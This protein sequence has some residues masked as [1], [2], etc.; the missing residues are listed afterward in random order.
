MTTN[1]FFYKYQDSSIID[2]L[3][4]Y[5]NLSVMWE[6]TVSKYSAAP[7]VEYLG[8]S[9]SYSELDEDV[10]H[11][12]KHLL[13]KGLKS[14]DTVC[15]LSDRSYDFIKAFLAA[16]T[17]GITVA[18]LPLHLNP[19]QIAHFF[20]EF[21]AAALLYSPDFREV[22][23]EDH[24]VSLNKINIS[25][26]AESSAPAFCDYPRETPC[27]IMFT[28]GTLGRSKGAVLSHEA[29]MQGII[30]GCYGYNAV[31][32]QKYLLVL[33]LFHVFGLIRS[34]LTPLYTGSLIFINTN[35]R[36]L[37]DDLAAFNP[38]VTV[39]VP[40]LVERGIA[41]SQKFG[42][43][44][45]GN[46]MKYIITGAAP[47]APY[48]AEDCAKYGITLCMGYGLTETACLVSG[49]PDMLGKPGSVGLL[50][51]NQEYRLVNDELW[52]KGRNLLTRYRDEEENQN[53]FEDGWFKTGD[54]VRIDDDG[55]MY[56]I[57]R[58]KEMLLRSNGENVYPSVVE[59]KFNALR[60]VNAS[61][62]YISQDEDGHDILAL[63]VL[64]RDTQPVIDN[65]T[66]KVASMMSDL[67][68][69]NDS[70]PSF[71]RAKKII[72]RR[73]DFKRTASMKI[74]RY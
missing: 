41:L 62:L 58:K 23:K 33:P 47:I 22:I 1:N 43:S 17:L 15:L 20:N 50:Y 70:L 56:V 28:G 67:N 27:I 12:R 51:P 69:I 30:N 29:V 2:S 73:E 36:M 44:M 25:E 39:L 57:G 49:N 35:P 45:F 46:S 9:Y 31:F 7:A 71:Q 21:G 54:A 32:G 14:T 8:K 16:E 61:Q 63:E 10:S 34:V 19:A 42:R 53:S 60:W 24:P 65:I 4:E 18:V 26:S 55:F 66:D 68:R 40:L 13:D 5:E 6:N 38:T 59:E 3:V 11:F 52:L 37:F 64:P 72:L 48:L 74:I